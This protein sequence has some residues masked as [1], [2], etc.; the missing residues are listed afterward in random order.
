MIINISAIETVSAVY[1]MLLNVH[2]PLHHISWEPRIPNCRESY[3]VERARADIRLVLIIN[4]PAL[5]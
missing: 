1:G 2:P 3:A 5:Q 4:T